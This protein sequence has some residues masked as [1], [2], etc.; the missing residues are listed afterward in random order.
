MPGP[1]LVR[2]TERRLGLVRVM[3][4][5]AAVVLGLWAG[6]RQAELWL[7]RPVPGLL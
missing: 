7:V 1:G 5:P 6:L 4:A 2:V 3:A